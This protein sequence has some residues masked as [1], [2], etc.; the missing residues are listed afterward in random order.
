MIT[1][2]D[3]K[4]GIEF[5]LNNGKRLLDDGEFLHQNK[6]YHSAI[7]LYILGYEEI[8]KAMIL[9]DLYSEGKSLSQEEYRKIFGGN[10]HI[11]KNEIRYEI[12]K[13]ELELMTDEEYTETKKY[14]ASNNIR[15]WEMSRQSALKSS[16]NALLIVRKFNDLKKK[17]LYIDYQNNEWQY[18]HNKFGD[19]MLDALCT[20]L[21]YN[22]LETYHRVWYNYDLTLMGYSNT[23]TMK[24]EDEEKI[25]QNK[26]VAEL[27]KIA[28]FFQTAKWRS[29]RDNSTKLILSI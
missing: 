29:M 26:H 19:K 14:A 9:D 10:S 4:T 7:P 6:R 24:I 2:S 23:T 22:A 13:R 16:D 20:V 11:K 21:Y 25:L 12:Q 1:S 5:C 17:F 27:T 18:F 28:E 15:W 3:L 8:N